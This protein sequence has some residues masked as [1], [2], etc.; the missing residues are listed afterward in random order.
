[1]VRVRRVERLHRGL[2]PTPAVLH[3]GPDRPE[4]G[5]RCLFP[6][7]PQLLLPHQQ[8]HPV[9]VHFVGRPRPDGFCAHHAVAVARILPAHHAAG[10]GAGH[11]WVRARLPVHH[12]GRLFPLSHRRVGRLGVAARH[13][14]GR[15]RGAGARRVLH[16]HAAV[17]PRV[18][19]AWERH[20]GKGQRRL[21]AGWG[22]QPPAVWLQRAAAVGGRCAAI[23][24]WVLDHRASDKPGTPTHTRTHTHT[25]D[26]RH[27]A[28][29][30]NDVCVWGGGG[31]TTPVAV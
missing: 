13:G 30:C 10:Q 28:P 14:H 12:H 15:G 8:L 4:Q 22:R 26:V 11:D 1:M 16:E 9:R 21:R 18:D 19:E 25:A 31:G 6:P 2:F 17:H 5:A 3:R 7:V 29:Y 20:D 27:C 23:E 24:G